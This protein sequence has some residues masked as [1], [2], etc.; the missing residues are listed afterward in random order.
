MAELPPRAAIL[1]DQ[2]SG[3]IEVAV[4]HAF[5][6]CA[7]QSRG[8]YDCDLEVLVVL[9]RCRRE[10][11]EIEQLGQRRTISHCIQSC[12]FIERHGIFR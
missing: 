10:P 4:E 6:P 9:S 2:Q 11:F 5:D 12:V 3:C 1:D 8:P 7:H